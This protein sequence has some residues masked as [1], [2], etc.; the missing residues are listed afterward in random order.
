MGA[1]G[2]GMLALEGETRTG[3]KAILV[4]CRRHLR[5]YLTLGIDKDG[6]GHEG[7]SYIGYGIGGGVQFIEILRRQGRDDL[8]VASNYDISAPWF[9][10]ETLPGGGRWNNLSDCGHGQAPW[11]VYSYACGRLAELAKADPAR[12]G[13][14]LPSPSASAGIDF[15]S[16]FSE[17]PGE[18]QLSYGALA[19]L[20]SWVWQNGPGRNPPSQYDGPRALGFLLL[21]RPFPAIA[22]PATV[23][24]LGKHFRGR[25]LVVSR[26]GFG[27]QDLYLA[28]EAGPHAAGH[29]QC[30]KGTFTLYGYGA[31]LVIDS[32]YGNDGEQLKSG[33]SYAHN[34]V[35]IDGQGQPMRYHNQ[36]SGEITGFHHSDLLDW[37]RVDARDAWGIRYDGDWRPSK[38]TPV[39]RAERT[40]LYVRGAEGVPPYVV[41]MDD[42]R[43]DASERDYTW[44]WHIPSSM[45]FDIAA[46]PWRAA[47]QPSTHAVLT[48]GQTGGGSA[49]FSFT[50]AEAGDY[51]LAGLVRAGGKDIGKSDS[52]F[53]TMDDGR[54]LTWDLNAGGGLAWSWVMDRGMDT[55]S[56]FHLEPGTHVARLE[57]REPEAELATLALVPANAELPASPEAVPD[58]AIVCRVSDARMGESPFEVIKA[59]TIMGTDASLEVFPVR[60][61]GG[62]VAT[63]W[64]ETSREGAHPRLQYTVRSND[65]RFVMVL[66]PRKAGI[67]RPQVVPDGEWGARVVWGDVE[68]TIRFSRTADAES[69]SATFERKRGGKTAARAW[70]DA[71]RDGRRVVATD[72]R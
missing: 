65:P 58:G 51:Q 16:H 33:S 17:V 43:K 20:M 32:G 23:L 15:L 71:P 27:P 19:G 55:A 72:G 9:V 6:C 48:S 26:S 3:E 37:I 5:D 36:S 28:V 45:A 56:V 46:T 25:G 24:P 47:A 35:L 42:I 68:D 61:L 18:R 7:P 34:V 70:L 44:Q 59:G 10:S 53:L 63:E 4:D 60:P 8:F 1:A 21:W 14:R 69:G 54:K 64:F 67:P 50:V 66:V 40:L 13:E 39:E 11:P 49:D 22:D 31:D 12:P 29:D 62:K 41:V 52:F 57:K 38:T 2:I 30:D